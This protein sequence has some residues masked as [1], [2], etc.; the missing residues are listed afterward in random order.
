MNKLVAPTAAVAM[1]IFTAGCNTPT[2][3]EA[4][5]VEPAAPTTEQAPESEA[6]TEPEVEPTTEEPS[7][8]PTEEMPEGEV[9]ARGNLILAAGEGA[10]IEGPD[11][12]PMVSFVV[13]SITVDAP[14]TSPNAEPPENGHFVTLDV[15]VETT[16]VVGTDDGI[17]SFGMT[18]YQFKPIAENGTTSNADPDTIASWYCYEEA[19]ILP[20]S[21]GP[22]EKATGLV[23]LDV[24]SPSGTLVFNDYFSSYGWEWEYPSE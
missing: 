2:T 7:E 19:Q 9:S 18:T 15:S 23:I 13:N 12:E 16:A 14:C 20:D 17:S 8:E 4:P 21:I 5:V 24:E 1:L 10:G 11:G 6:T 3:A 22:G